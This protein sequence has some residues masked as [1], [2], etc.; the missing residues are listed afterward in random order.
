MDPEVGEAFER[1]KKLLVQNGC[2]LVEVDYSEIEKLDKQLGL[3]IL[4]YEFYDCLGAYLK[5]NK[6][7]LTVEQ[8]FEKIASPDVRMIFQ[9]LVLPDAPNRPSKDVY[10]RNMK[11]VRPQLIEAVN[12]LFVKNEIQLLA[13]PAL[14]CLAPKLGHVDGMKTLDKMVRNNSPASNSGTP[15]LT[16]PIAKTENNLCI[17]LHLESLFLQDQYL[18]KCGALIHK[19]FQ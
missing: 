9:D 11:I 2:K 17:G 7:E 14:A 10:E 8:L 16:I 12:Q 13:Y 15:C 1:A 5:E 4:F 3:S 18:L 19:L 6:L